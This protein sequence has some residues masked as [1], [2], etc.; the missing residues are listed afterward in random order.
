M[1]TTPQT[2][3]QVKSGGLALLAA[4]TVATPTGFGQPYIPIPE[5]FPGTSRAWVDA[6]RREAELTYFFQRVDTYRALGEDYG[7]ATEYAADDASAFF[8]RW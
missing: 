3:P 8:A 7:T 5:T 1:T 4:M 2:S 6:I